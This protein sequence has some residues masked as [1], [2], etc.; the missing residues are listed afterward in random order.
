[1]DHSETIGEVYQQKAESL[2]ITFASSSDPT[3]THIGK[4]KIHLSATD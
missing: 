1:M 3:E 4:W 2:G